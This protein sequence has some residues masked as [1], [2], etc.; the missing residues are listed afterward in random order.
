MF[1]NKKHST[2]TVLGDLKARTKV[3]MKHFKANMTG[4]S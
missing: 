3:R 1:E 2:P 4:V